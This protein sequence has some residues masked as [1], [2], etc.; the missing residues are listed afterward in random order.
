MGK[1]TKMPLSGL[2]GL[3]LNREGIIVIWLTGVKYYQGFMLVEIVESNRS[4]KR[5]EGKERKRKGRK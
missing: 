2:K 5:K 3:R 1:M 4:L